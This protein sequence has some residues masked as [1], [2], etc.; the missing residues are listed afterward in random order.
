MALALRSRRPEP[1]VLR[2][3]RRLLVPVVE[4]PESVRALELACRLASDS[5]ATVVA[6]A[7]V[8]VAPLLPLDAHM[9]EEERSAR[10]V[11]ERAGATADSY[12]VTLAPRIL[13]AVL[14]ARRSS[15]S[16]A[17]SARSS[18]SSAA[19]AAG[20]A[21]L[22]RRSSAGRSERSSRT[23]RAAWSWSRRP[24][25]RLPAARP[26]ATRRTT[27]FYSDSAELARR[28]RSVT[29]SCPS[30]PDVSTSSTSRS[31]TRRS[32]GSSPLPGEIGPMP[33]ET[34]SSRA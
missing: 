3:Y 29:H 15:A 22:G 24:S 25:L 11:L 30:R 1:R 21:A 4:G 9:L 2:G 28:T 26:S 34:S 27:P 13:R 18:W 23:R 14:P 31:S 20:R 19:H 10:A 12:G 33:T 16:R 6:V 32:P 5:G 17:R 7:V 8:E